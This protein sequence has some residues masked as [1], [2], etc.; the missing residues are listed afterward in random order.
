VCKTDYHFKLVFCDISIEGR[1]VKQWGQPLL[2]ACGMA[3]FGLFTRVYNGIQEF[4]IH[5]KQEVGCFDKI[6]LGPTIQLETMEKPGNDI[7]KLF[8]ECYMAKKGILYDVV[9]SEEGGRFY[10]EQN[11]NI[12][13][14]IEPE[15]IPPPGYWWCTYRTLNELVQIN[16]IL[17]IQL[18]TL[19]S[20][21]EIG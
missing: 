19:L 13:I 2:E 8:F 7:E 15:L 3:T 1:E 11:R 16:N 21:L 10:H 6:E 12:I 9:L 14:D 5:A 18:R 4:L 17:N 20:L